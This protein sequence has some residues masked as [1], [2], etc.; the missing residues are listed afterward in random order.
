[1]VTFFIVRPIFSSSPNLDE[2]VNLETNHLLLQGASLQYIIL[3]QMFENINER[4]RLI[5]AGDMDGSYTSLDSL[6]ADYEKISIHLDSLYHN[7]KIEKP[8]TTF[9]PPIVDVILPLLNRN[10]R[11]DL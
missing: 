1:M 3:H 7:L 6:L 4:I 9:A 8:A 10:F 11:F 2:D 5:R